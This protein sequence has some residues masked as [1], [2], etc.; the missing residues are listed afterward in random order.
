[1]FRF[2]GYEIRVIERVTYGADNEESYTYEPMMTRRAYM[3]KRYNTN[4]V[5]GRN[6]TATYQR[7]M[8]SSSAAVDGPMIFTDPDVAQ[9]AAVVATWRFIQDAKGSKAHDT[10]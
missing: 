8:A 10:Q 7:Y 9:Y 3:G 1:M 2:A 4:L 6:A 5:V